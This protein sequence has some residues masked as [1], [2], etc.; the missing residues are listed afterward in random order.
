MKIWMIGAALF[1]VAGASAAAD[2]AVSTTDFPG[3]SDTIF[4]ALN[5]A[6]QIVGAEDDAAGHFHAIAQL[7]G[8][9]RLLDPNGVIGQSA[10]SFAF[11][12][13]NRGDIAGSFVDAGG[14]THGYL[15]HRDDSI[16]QIDFPGSTSTHAFGVNDLGRVIGVYNDSAGSAHAFL[17]RGGAYT[18]IDLPGSGQTT[19][20]LSINDRNQIVG[21]FGGT[22]TTNGFGYF[23][24]EDG[25]FTLVTAPG[26][27]PQ[28]TLFISINNR[29]QILGAYTDSTNAQQNFVLQ[30]KLYAPFNLPVR[31]GASFVSAQTINDA[32]EIVGYYGDSAGNLHAFVAIAQSDHDE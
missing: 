26:S 20:P 12:I 17:L 22:A 2:Y 6:G 9:L 31:L 7:D 5:D 29:E 8:H 18:T 19:V 11:S 32:A 3:A 23:Q 14:S 15:R 28:G 10:R 27:V 25:K 4:F 1:G 13:N 21:E 24:R 30:D 16:E